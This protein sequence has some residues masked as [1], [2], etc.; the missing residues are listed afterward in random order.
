MLQI[1]HHGALIISFWFSR[2]K[3]FF[4]VVKVWNRAKACWKLCSTCLEPRDK[5][6]PAKQLLLNVV[7]RYLVLQCDV[8]RYLTSLLE[9]WEH[10]NLFWNFAQFTCTGHF[11]HNGFYSRKFR[12]RSNMDFSYGSAATIFSFWDQ[13]RGGLKGFN[14][15]FAHA[16]LFFWFFAEGTDLV[17]LLSTKLQVSALTLIQA[18]PTLRR[19]LREYLERVIPVIALAPPYSRGWVHPELGKLD[20]GC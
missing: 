20:A 16:W 9:T 4:P 13:F 7:G 10:S 15:A 19:N 14:V 1:P 12:T 6:L 5:F 2:G 17:A 11:D 18:S 3:V 8:K